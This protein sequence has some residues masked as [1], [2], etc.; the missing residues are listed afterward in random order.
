MPGTLEQLLD[1]SDQ[2]ALVTGASRGLG[3][4]TARLLCLGGASVVLTSR[5]QSD[6]DATVVEFEADGCDPR[7]LLPLA[8][9]MSD[10]EQVNQLA[11]TVLQRW[12]KIDILVNNAA[13]MQAGSYDKIEIEDWQR[14]IDANLTGVYALI[15]AVAPGMQA[16][17]Y[18]RI[19]NIASISAQTGGV[20]GGVHY[21]A[22]KGGL[23]AMTKTLARDLAADNITVN[24][25]A[26]GQIATRPEQFTSQALQH[27]VS[28][29]PMGRLGVPE[30]IAYGV[31]YLASPM[32]AYVTGATLDI[33]GGILKR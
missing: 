31:L 29:I 32:G 11:E 9:D 6:L 15:R 25:I 12:E 23:I 3:K 13:L 30:D 14:L 2:V 28:L 24:A 27:V 19:I 33:N 17:Q 1:F 22:T 16:R 20:S 10:L 4:A 26:P 18:G 7:R 5:S 21:A 8:A